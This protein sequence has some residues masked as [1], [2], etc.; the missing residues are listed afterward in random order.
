MADDDRV[1]I[2]VKAEF[3][4]QLAERVD[5]SDEY[6]ANLYAGGKQFRRALQQLE[7]ITGCSWRH[8][9]RFSG[10]IS[11]NSL[12]PPTLYEDE[13]TWRWGT[14]WYGHAGILN[15]N[16]PMLF[17][18]TIRTGLLAREAAIL[19]SPLILDRMEGPRV[20]CEQSEYLA[21]RLLESKNQ[22]ELWSQA[23]HGLR[24]STRVREQDLIDFF[25]FYEMMVGHR[26]Y[27][28]LWNRLREFGTARLTVADYYIVFNN[29]ASRPTRQKFSRAEVRL[30][31][32]LT[33]KPEIKAGEI[34]RSLRMSIPT[35]MKS[36]ADLSRKAALRFTV[37]VDMRRLGLVEHLLLVKTNRVGEVL[38]MLSRFPYC[39][40]AFRTYGGSDLFCV[41]DVPT[42]HVGF[43]AD[44]VGGMIRRQI[45]S[46]A[47][48]LVVERDFQTVNFGRYDPIE[49]RWDVHWDTW[50]MSLRE[51]LASKSEPILWSSDRNARVIVDKLDL[52]I[53]SSLQTDCRLPYAAVGRSL[54][55]SGAYIGRKVDRLTRENVFR[56]AV[57]PL[58]IAAE[59]WSILSLSCSKSVA[60]ILTDYLNGLPAWR[61]GYVT[62]DFEGL[63]AM[64][65]APSGEMKQFFKAIDDRLIRY[66]RARAESINSVGEWVIAR[67]LP[68]DA[69]PWD[70]IDDKGQ[71]M[72]DETA[73]HRLLS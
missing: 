25:E 22:K 11:I 39:R 69:T 52:K 40:Q 72:F 66:G 54:G 15:I 8:S 55:V 29:L 57:W 27:V 43:T 5:L 37:I 12:F 58:K 13:N 50:G 17:I 20:L 6:A 19:L 45:V 46:E 60:S 32:L 26:L 7:E 35:A 16:P 64:V 34:A 10:S 36:T 59:D 21:Y 31:N 1:A 24:R 30:L 23:R 18:D 53:L 67:W 9:E 73:Y 41:F 4:H 70:L 48:I 47:R 71:W 56:Y 65:W 44:F 33:K 49:G 14:Q 2:W 3:D 42:E 63:L 51:K 38:Q 61:G 68:V 62:G 28:D